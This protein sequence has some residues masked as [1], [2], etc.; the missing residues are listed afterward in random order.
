MKQISNIDAICIALGLLGIY[1]TLG[2][3]E[4]ETISVIQALFR[5]GAYSAAAYFFAIIGSAKMGQ[6]IKQIKCFACKPNRRRR[7]VTL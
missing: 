2:A 4:L 6:A 7:G 5:I 1:G 3:L